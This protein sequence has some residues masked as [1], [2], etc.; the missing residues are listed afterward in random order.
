MFCKSFHECAKQELNTKHLRVLQQCHLKC[1]SKIK[2]CSERKIIFKMLPQRIYWKHLLCQHLFASL[3]CQGEQWLYLPQAY[4][5]VQVEKQ[6]SL[7]AQA[8]TALI[9]WMEKSI[10]L[11]FIFREGRQDHRGE[12]KC[13][14]QTVIGSFLGVGLAPQTLEVILGEWQSLV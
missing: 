11:P 8:T 6:I 10:T 3:G 12:N 5:P 9:Q 4:N 14:H 13:I 7:A 1:A 2:K